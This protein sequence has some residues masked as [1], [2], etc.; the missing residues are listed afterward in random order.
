MFKKITKSLV[1]SSLLLGASAYA[2]DLTNVSY[3]VIDSTINKAVLVMPG[4]E[5]GVHS[6]GTSS[7]YKSLKAQFD[8]EP[9][10]NDDTRELCLPALL[11]DATGSDGANDIAEK[12]YSVDFFYINTNEK[13]ESSVDAGSDKAVFLLY[14]V[15]TEGLTQHLA[16]E[17]SKDGYPAVDVTEQYKAEG[18]KFSPKTG[19]TV[20]AIVIDDAIKPPKPTTTPTDTVVVPDELK[21]DPS[22]PA[23][24]F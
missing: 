5:I 10:F 16:G 6:A 18:F 14:Y 2:V 8:G 12:C 1:A 19:A 17:M 15:P 3:Y 7:D 20:D 4:A 9:T 24:P 21:N 13:T 22:F 23:Q 11:S